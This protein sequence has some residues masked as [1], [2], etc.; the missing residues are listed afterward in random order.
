MKTRTQSLKDVKPSIEIDETIGNTVP[1]KENF[2]FDSEE[3]SSKEDEQIKDFKIGVRRG[4]INRKYY[5]S[6]KSK[7]KIIRDNKISLTRQKDKNEV[8]EYTVTEQVGS[9]ELFLKTWYKMYN[10]S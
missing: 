8:T 4:M 1:V 9:F 6:H 10:N 3:I 2:I 5:Q 7:L